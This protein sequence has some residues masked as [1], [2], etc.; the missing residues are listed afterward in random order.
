MRKTVRS[1]KK[2]VKQA[3]YVAKAAQE[4]N[5]ISLDRAEA[6]AIS[7][8]PK[9]HVSLFIK[10][11]SKGLPKDMRIE[12]FGSSAA[13]IIGLVRRWSFDAAP[14][15]LSFEDLMAHEKIVSGIAAPNKPQEFN[16]SLTPIPAPGQEGF[17]YGRIRYHCSGEQGEE[18]W[19]YG[20][21][22]HGKFS[23]SGSF[24]TYVANN[25]N[26]NNMNYTKQ[27]KP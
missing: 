22:L 8:R 15:Q 25:E 26:D 19:V 3:K 21:C 6:D 11:G 9:L 1:A 4:S 27:T 18:E 10:E 17:F 7:S 20:F 24:E 23:S 5:R 14:A 12:N 13:T 16:S 2:S